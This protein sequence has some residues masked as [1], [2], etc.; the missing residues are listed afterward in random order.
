MFDHKF[1]DFDKEL[2]WTLEGEQ[3]AVLSLGDVGMFDELW[4]HF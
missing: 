1:I 2:A 3:G 4:V